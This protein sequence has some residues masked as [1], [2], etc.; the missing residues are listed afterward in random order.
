MCTS[1]TGYDG[2]TGLGT[3]NGLGWFGGAA[4]TIT[5]TPVQPVV[6]VDTSSGII[7]FNSDGSYAGNI[8]ISKQYYSPDSIGVVGNEVWTANIQFGGSIGR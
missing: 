7:P 1:A 8:I 3:L 2:P 4:L 6:W 5:P